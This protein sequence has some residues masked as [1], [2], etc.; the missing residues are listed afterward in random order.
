MNIYRASHYEGVFALADRQSTVQI[1]DSCDRRRALYIC[2]LG[3]EQ[4]LYFVKSKFVLRGAHKGGLNHNVEVALH[5]ACSFHLI[6][7]LVRG[8]RQT[9]QSQV[10]GHVWTAREV[11][12]AGMCMAQHK[13]F[14]RTP[15]G[16]VR[17]QQRWRACIRQDIPAE[18]HSSG[19]CEREL[20]NRSIDRLLRQI[21]D[22]RRCQCSAN[23]RIVQPRRVTRISTTQHLPAQGT[24]IICLP[25]HA[26][27]T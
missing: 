5:V 3:T 25:S 27:C 19:R 14:L 2:A 24:K 12:V 6:S 8:V 20:I 23:T 17:R 18:C 26:I 4:R 7:S 10:H 1:A 13:R 22:A 16:V 21:V 15:S 11:R 9:M